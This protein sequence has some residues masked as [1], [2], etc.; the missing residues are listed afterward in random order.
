ML[1]DK[2]RWRVEDL[3]DRYVE[4][5]QKAR[6]AAGLS[7]AAGAAPPVVQATAADGTFFDEV[8]LED[9]PVRDGL[10]LGCGHCFSWRTFRSLCDATL[11]APLALRSP[12][13]RCPA[14]GCGEAIP[15]S[16]VERLLG[17]ERASEYR[18]IQARCF[19]AANPSC[20]PC[21]E[22]DCDQVTGGG[23]IHTGCRPCP[24][25]DCD[26]VQSV[27]AEA[28]CTTRQAAP[29]G[30]LRPSPSRPYT[31]VCILGRGGG[32]GSSG[33]GGH[34]EVECSRGHPFCFRCHRTSHR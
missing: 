4:S 15:P 10:A 18:A 11:S 33:G 28:G 5:S 22:A 3:A 21:P 14:D 23:R 2:F 8:L 26:Q 13:L 31:Q 16:L 7:S 25:A 32:G 27:V 19:A 9:V 29:L 34:D 30:T 6:A 24:E 20:R 12:V 1:L 17:T